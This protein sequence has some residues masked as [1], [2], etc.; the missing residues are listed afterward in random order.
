MH[1]IEHHLDVFSRENFGLNGAPQLLH[2]ITTDMFRDG[3]DGDLFD[4]KTIIPTLCG[5]AMLVL[6]TGCA[7]M[8]GDF[9]D[10][11]ADIRPS[12]EDQITTDTKRQILAHNEYGA[13]ACDWR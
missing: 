4:M 5:V 6:L 2:S 1:F 11:S 3:P 13:R 8:T 10:V 9:C 7:T 12:V